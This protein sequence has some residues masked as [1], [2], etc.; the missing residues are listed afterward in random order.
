MITVTRWVDEKTTNL[1]DIEKLL[2][3]PHPNEVPE[4]GTKYINWE[5]QKVFDKDKKD[6]F[7][8]REITYNYYTFS[9]DQIPGGEEISDDGT[10]TKRGFVIPYFSAGKVRYIISKNNDGRLDMKNVILI[11]FICVIVIFGLTG[12]SY[13]DTEL[14]DNRESQYSQIQK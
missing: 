13:Y 8:G 14:I 3:S 1:E 5:I 6:V 2:D 7:Y 12:C 4:S 9:V 10:Y 11:I